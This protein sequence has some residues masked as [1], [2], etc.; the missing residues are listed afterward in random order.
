MGANDISHF[1]HTVEIR[2]N[3][4]IPLD[5]FYKETEL[6]KR[7]MWSLINPGLLLSQA[8]IYFVYG[9]EQ[10]LLDD[11]DISKYFSK[12]SVN[13]SGYCDLSD[14]DKSITIRR[15][16][17]NAIA[18]CR[19][20][21]EVRT[22]DGRITKDGDVWFVFTDQKRDGSDKIKIEM[23]FP[24]FG[25]VVEAAGGHTLSKLKAQQNAP[26]DARTSRG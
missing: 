8:Y 14:I 5:N 20:S 10:G 13:Y 16:V 7:R 2:K 6:E 23:S 18:H 9:Q 26:A 19:Y 15:R 11:L 12:I 1:L 22:T 3:E 17:R 25:N 4:K 24:T 21:I